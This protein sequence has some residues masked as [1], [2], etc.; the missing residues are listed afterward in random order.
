MSLQHTTG[1]HEAGLEVWLHSFLTSALDRGEQSASR[2]GQFTSEDGVQYS[3]NRRMG[4]PQ[5]HSRH[6]EKLKKKKEV[7]NKNTVGLQ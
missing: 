3:L 7:R 6:V 4:G 2:L 1:R 5:S